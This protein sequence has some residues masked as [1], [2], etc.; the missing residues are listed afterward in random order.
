MRIKQSTLESRLQATR[1]KILA[2][3]EDIICASCGTNRNLDLSHLISRSEIKRY[4]LLELY[5]WDKNLAWH[6]NEFANGCHLHWE[7]GTRKGADWDK[8]IKL[9]TELL[10]SVEPELLQIILNRWEGV[11]A[12]ISFGGY[13]SN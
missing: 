12:R 13:V 7:N 5:Y 2:S 4:D 3:E 10:E 11:T 6:C 1:E 8:N 9:L